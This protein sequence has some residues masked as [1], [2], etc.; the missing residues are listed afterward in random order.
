MDR[1]SRDCAA[2]TV[3]LAVPFWQTLILKILSAITAI[4][5]VWIVTQAAKEWLMSMTTETYE[6]WDETG[7]HK[8]TKPSILGITGVGII[9]IVGVIL[10]MGWLMKKKK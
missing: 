7:Y 10:A 3:A 8:V 2:N 4:V 1:P 9:A 6:W 5:I